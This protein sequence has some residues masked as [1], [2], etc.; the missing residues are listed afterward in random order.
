MNYTRKELIETEATMNQMRNSIYGLVRFMDK[1]GI[2]DSK[3]KFRRIGQ[4][5]ART[6][7]KYWKPTDLVTINNLKDVLTTIY[8][9]I[10]NSSISIDIDDLKK[11]VRIQDHKCALC[12]YQYDDVNIAGCEILIAMVSEFISLINLD[13]GDLSSVFLE[14]IEVR[15]SRAYG[16]N[17]CIQVLK[18]NIGRGV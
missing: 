5:I 8:Q 11:L 9:K 7:I 10:L 2:K 16:N 13:S 18:Y 12:K 1:N 15:E 14:P 6:Y 4:N 3:Q 17:S